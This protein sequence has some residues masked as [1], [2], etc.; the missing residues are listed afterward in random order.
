MNVYGQGGKCKWKLF[1]GAFLMVTCKKSCMCHWCTHMDKL[2]SCVCLSE[3]THDIANSARP[4]GSMDGD[5]WS[6]GS[7]VVSAIEWEI[8]CDRQKRDDRGTRG[9]KE[10]WLVE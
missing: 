1:L 8:N 2:V 7:D 9:E 5:R 4:L 6:T 10:V 3:E